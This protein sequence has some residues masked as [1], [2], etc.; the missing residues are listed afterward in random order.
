MTNGEPRARA[1]I[2]WAEL[3]ERIEVATAAS[4]ATGGGLKEEV[5][6]SILDTRARALSRP[7]RSVSD[8]VTTDVL[9]FMRG[10]ERYAIALAELLEVH[11]PRTLTSLPGADHPVLGLVAWRGRA[12]TVVDVGHP[13][14]GTMAQAQM[15]DMTRVLVVDH[16]HGPFGIVADDVLEVMPLADDDMLAMPAN[17]SERGLP[18]RGVTKDGVTMVDSELLARRTSTP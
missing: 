9:V 10:S 2:D 18:L 15:K 1:A 17:R 16:L 14:A 4:S 13:V 3:R 11:R 7:L 6:R 5:A 12:L 8:T